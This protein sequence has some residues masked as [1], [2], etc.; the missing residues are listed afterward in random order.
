[1]RQTEDRVQ[2][3]PLMV[4]VADALTDLRTTFATGRT[5]DL[6]WRQVQL[7]GL[8]GLLEENQERPTSGSA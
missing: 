3:A 1:M 5:T 6:G 7:R 8:I 4:A 2:S